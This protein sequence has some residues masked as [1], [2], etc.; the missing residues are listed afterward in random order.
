[1]AVRWVLEQ[2]LVSSAIVGARTVDQLSDTLAAGGW[3]LPEA[4]RERLDTISALPRRYPRA[5]EETMLQR[6][7][8]AV[9][10]PTRSR[11]AGAQ[12]L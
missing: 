1:V 4:A 7:E 11:Q 8:Q 12:G 5:M 10:V 2:P 3:R 6:R 9:R